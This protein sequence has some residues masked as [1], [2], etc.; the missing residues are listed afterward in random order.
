MPLDFHVST[1]ESSTYKC[2]APKDKDRLKSQRKLVSFYNSIPDSH[3]KEVS[4]WARIR[5]DG[6]SYLTHTPVGVRTSPP[7]SL[8][9][10]A[11]LSLI[12][13]KSGGRAVYMETYPK[14]PST[15]ASSGEGPLVPCVTCGG[16][17]TIPN[18]SL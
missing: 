3:K 18:L 7:N 5:E 12:T 17:A 6:S 16:D 1:K 14:A 8:H 2:Q 11:G 15:L 10:R 9:I 4:R 13:L